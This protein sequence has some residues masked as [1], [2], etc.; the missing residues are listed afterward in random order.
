MVLQIFG[1][2]ALT[3]KIS[4]PEK[5]CGFPVGARQTLRLLTFARIG[6]RNRVDYCAFGA[7][8]HPNVTCTVAS[9]APRSTGYQGQAG[10]RRDSSIGRAVWLAGWLGG[11]GADWL[12]GWLAGCRAQGSYPGQVLK[13]SYSGEPLRGAT[14][15]VTARGAIQESYSREL[16]KGAAQGSY[17]GV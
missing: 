9:R 11:A 17:P 10:Q 8:R 5:I 2:E 16:L 3:I 14:R 15:G 6:P 12:A 7:T 4:R 13:G 1:E